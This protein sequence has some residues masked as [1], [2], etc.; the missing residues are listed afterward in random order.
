MNLQKE[1]IFGSDNP[2]EAGMPI[3]AKPKAKFSI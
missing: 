1:I 3:D 2:A